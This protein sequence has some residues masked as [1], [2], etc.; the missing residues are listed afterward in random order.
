MSGQDG[1]YKAL[2][3]FRVEVGRLKKEV[4]PVVDFLKRVQGAAV[5]LEVIERTL[6]TAES[7]LGIVPD[8]A[9]ASKVPAKA[10]GS[11]VG[12]SPRV[13]L[14]TVLDG[15][16]EPSA[17]L[18]AA[19]DTAANPAAV[20]D[21]IREVALGFFED[22]GQQIAR[23]LPKPAPPVVA[24]PLAPP[25]PV[26]SKPPA[27]PPPPPPAPPARATTRAFVDDLGISAGSVV[28]HEQT[29]G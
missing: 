13:E 6:K 28:E 15:P 24:A 17:L 25:A 8:A 21:A 9:G 27:P 29:K 22:L 14:V 20:V 3:G 11:P 4:T 18:A 5:R 10:S 26:A 19:L 16:P 1:V 7:K 23:A 12:D 2:E